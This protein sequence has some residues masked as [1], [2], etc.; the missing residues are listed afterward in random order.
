[1]WYDDFTQTADDDVR[2]LLRAHA[3]ALH[4]SRP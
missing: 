2:S 4:G 1:M 3:E